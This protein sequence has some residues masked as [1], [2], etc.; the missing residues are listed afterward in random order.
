MPVATRDKGTKAYERHKLRAA[1]RQKELSQSGREIYRPGC[2]KVKNWRRKRRALDSLEA[3]CKSYFPDVFYLPFSA[4]HLRVIAKM[5]AIV[6]DGGQLAFAMPRGSGKSALCAA[7]ALWAVLKGVHL[8]VLL[9]GATETDATTTLKGIREHLETNDILLEDFPEVCWPIRC[10]EGIPQRR[11]LWKGRLIRM[12]LKEGEIVFP[13]LPASPA[14]GAI[15]GVA[16]LT[17]RIRGRKHVRS[18]GREV[19]PSLVFLDDPQ[20]DEAAASPAQCAKRESIINGAVLGLAGPDSKISAFMPCTVICPDDLADRLLNRDRNPQWRGELTKLI[21]QWPKGADSEKLWDEYAEMRRQILREGRDL[22]ECDR[23]VEDHHDAM[24]AGS[25]VAWAERHPGAVSTLQYAYN[26]RLE[27]G[28]AAFNAE[29]QNEPPKPKL[30]EEQPLDAHTL[31]QRLNRA[32]WGTAPG[33]ST[34]L[35]AFIDCSKEVLYWVVCG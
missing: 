12:E 4:D 26:I 24:H 25:E 10:L 6:N 20:D 18:D 23:F 31:C 5:E 3:F 27:R 30:L 32:A 28:D 22:R 11:L 15:L 33:R 13:S 1:K 8:Y 14:A 7:A 16:G 34:V 35:T 29:Y 9:I 17:G 2:L 19:R 21:Y